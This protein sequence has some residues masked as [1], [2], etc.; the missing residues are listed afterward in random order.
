M[1]YR[2]LKLARWLSMK[3][4]ILLAIIVGVGFGL[5]LW[6]LLNEPI[7]QAVPDRSLRI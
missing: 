4:Y 1:R 3:Q 7:P 6:W 2:C 5:L